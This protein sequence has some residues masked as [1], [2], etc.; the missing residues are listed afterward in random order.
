MHAT[1]VSINSF[2]LC[3]GRKRI[4][5]KSAAQYK[6]IFRLYKKNENKLIT[7]AANLRNN[8]AITLIMRL[9]NTGLQAIHQLLRVH[10]GLHIC[11][12]IVKN[13]IQKLTNRRTALYI[14]NVCW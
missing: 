3:T 13:N 4:T 9:N 5:Q 6:L 8:A 1:D 7:A 11:T 10:C 2:G 12:A 14:C